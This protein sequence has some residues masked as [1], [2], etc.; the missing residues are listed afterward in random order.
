LFDSANR[1]R[2]AKGLSQLQWSE[3]LATAAREHAQRMAQSN[4][5]AHQLPGEPS[6][7]ERGRQAGARYSV[8][9]ENVAE[10]PT[11]EAIHS[12]WM[13]S[14][15]HRANLLAPELNSVGIAVVVAP[16]R[17][18]G[19]RVLFVV[20]DFSLAVANL[21]LEEQEKQ[22]AALLAKR[23]LQPSDATDEARKTCETDHGVTGSRAALVVR[24]EA[25]DL[26]HL[27]VNLDK[28]IQSG[29]YHA[30]AVGACE[31]ASA[32]EGARFRLAVLLF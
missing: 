18:I 21:S 9:A 31:P 19:G 14:P 22:V 26:S 12:G 20:Q 17:R 16:E 27:P 28:E 29:H 6:P 4:V 15:P 13:H 24:F 32:K 10:G 11:P 8:F 23:G 30:S 2:A 7:E 3:S 1:E 5:L 25:S